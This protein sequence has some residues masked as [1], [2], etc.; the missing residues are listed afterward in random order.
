MIIEVCAGIILAFVILA[1]L[2]HIATAFVWLLK[3]G[4]C[5][6][7]AVF[8]LSPAGLSLI[9]PLV[10]LVALCALPFLAFV[11]L[12]RGGAWLRIIGLPKLRKIGLPKLHGVLSPKSWSADGAAALGWVLLASTL[13][14][15]FLAL[16]I[17]RGDDPPSVV[18]NLFLIGVVAALALVA[19]GGWWK[20]ADLLR[21]PGSLA[22]AGLV[23]AVATGSSLVLVGGVMARIE[24]GGIGGVLL[25]VGG[26]LMFVGGAVMLGAWSERSSP[27]ATDQDLPHQK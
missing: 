25:A 7:L 20:M 3:W 12:K 1:N 10:A 17:S 23:G 2:E 24:S 13:L 18:L 15:Y 21:H 16:A 6:A 22:Q 9:L 19:V 11:A 14:F 27:K 5:L 8:A 4:L 26:F